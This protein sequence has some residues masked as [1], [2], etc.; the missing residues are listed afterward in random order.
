MEP[1]R[2]EGEVLLSAV[3]LVFNERRTLPRCLDALVALCDEVVV[4][5]DVSTDGTWEYLQART[6][7][8]AV[9][10]RHTTFAAQREYGKALARGRWVLSMDGDEFVTPELARAIRGALGRP[11]APDGF[12]LRRRNRVPATLEGHV[13]SKHPRLVRAARCVWQE[14]DSPHSPL[15]VEGLRMEVL[16][17]GF[18]E[19]EALPNLA[20]AL[21]KS[22][23]RSVIVAA[24][25]RARGRR[26]GVLRVVGSTVGRFLKMYLRQGAWRHGRDGFLVACAAAFEAFAKHAFLCEQP[27][28]AEALMDGGPGSYPKGAPVVA[29]GRAEGQG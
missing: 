20:T 27:Q 12:Y 25:E 10:H 24:Q 17:G 18:L 9:Q 19:H 11:D 8:R 26:S 2:P 3:V 1:S 5:D 13:W 28:E 22:I 15:V 7:V 29:V 4:V 21:R 6:D 14:T 23:N 16:E